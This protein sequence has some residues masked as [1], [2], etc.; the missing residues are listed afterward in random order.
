VNRPASDRVLT[1]S[2]RG[3][4]ARDTG[5]GAVVGDA[6][7]VRNDPH[8]GA[9]VVAIAGAHGPVRA[10]RSDIGARI[11]AD[12]GATKAEAAVAALPSTGAGVLAP[13]GDVLAERIVEQWRAQVRDHIAAQPAPAVEPRAGDDADGTTGTQETDPLREYG[14]ALLVVVVTPAAVFAMQLGPGDILLRADDG[15]TVR[16]VATEPADGVDAIESLALADAEH[17]FRH[18]AVDRTARDIALVLAATGLDDPTA[19][20]DPGAT[21]AAE[22]AAHADEHGVDSIED[23]LEQCVAGTARTD[24]DEVTV[25][26]VFPAAAV[27][28]PPDVTDPRLAATVAVPALGATA[29][30]PAL[31]TSTLPAVTAAA[32]GTTS[33]R[34]RRWIAAAVAAGVLALAIGGVLALSR[35]NGSTTPATVTS[36]TPKKTTSTTARPSTTTSPPTTAAPTTAPTTVAPVT[37]LPVVVTAPP[38]TAAPP[39][40]TTPTRPPT[41]TV[42]PTTVPVTPSSPPTT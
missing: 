3:S 10:A 41:T 33:K 1:S 39:R 17:G 9:T 36:T 40:T 26:V 7:A 27:A 30:T 38:T 18:A 28:A 29:A 5:V 4:T 24:G 6:V 19:D 21:I 11:A 22:L 8:A 2:V 37:T 14:T 23:E 12:I 42:P 31:A 20:R 25:A 35:D 13:L 34:R 32:A 16:P 15:E